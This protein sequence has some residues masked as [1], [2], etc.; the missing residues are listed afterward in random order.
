MSIRVDRFYVLCVTCS[1]IV[2]AFTLRVNRGGEKE[3]GSLD[4]CPLGHGSVIGILRARLARFA[5]I[6]LGELVELT[7]YDIVLVFLFPIKFYPGKPV[8]LIR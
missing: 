2:P 8:Y 3:T 6:E 1:R 4:V 5:L 7:C